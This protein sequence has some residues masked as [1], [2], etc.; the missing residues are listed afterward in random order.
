MEK[1]IPEKLIKT[2]QTLLKER[3]EKEGHHT[4][5]AAALIT[6]SGKI[7]HINCDSADGRKNLT[8]KITDDDFNT[9]SKILV[10]DEGGYS[11][12]AIANGKIYVLYER[13]WGKNGLY[14][15]VLE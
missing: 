4:V 13:N 11:D 8:I 12:I 2:A 15:R 3:Y 1:T 9:V 7:Y 10:D 14:F 5:V 6:K